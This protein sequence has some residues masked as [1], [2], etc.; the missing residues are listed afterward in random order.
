MVR[1]IGADCGVEFGRGP[2][3]RGPG[4]SERRRSRVRRARLPARA[5]SGNQSRPRNCHGRRPAVPTSSWR[6]CLAIAS[7]STLEFGHRALL[8]LLLF[9]ATPRCLLSVAS[10]GRGLLIHGA[11]RIWAFVTSQQIEHPPLPQLRRLLKRLHLH[12]HFLSVFARRAFD[13]SAMLIRQRPESHAGDT[14][15]AGQSFGNGWGCAESTSDS[16]PSQLRLGQF[17]AVRQDRAA[18]LRRRQSDH[19]GL[20]T[21]RDTDAARPRPLRGARPGRSSPD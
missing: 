17:H 12:G 20:R 5:F 9:L 21:S 10:D 15:L 18:S 8:R 6:L 7:M 1:L 11:G 3:R 19:A 14:R 16:L 2:R 4:Y 13:G